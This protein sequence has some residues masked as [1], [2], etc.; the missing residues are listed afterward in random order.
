MREFSLTPFGRWRARMG[1]IINGFNKPLTAKEAAALL[2]ITGPAVTK[3]ERLE[4]LDKKT[5]LVCAAL[6][7][8]LEPIS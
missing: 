8:S 4:V 5:A 2:E 6:E 7:N 3:L 1:L